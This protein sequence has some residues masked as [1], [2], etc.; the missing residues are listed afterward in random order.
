[1][2][3]SGGNKFNQSTSNYFPLIVKGIS[4]SGNAGLNIGLDYKNPDPNSNLPADAYDKPDALIK[5]QNEVYLT[6][7]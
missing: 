6:A 5:T 1:M 3:F 7:Y 2:T 4:L